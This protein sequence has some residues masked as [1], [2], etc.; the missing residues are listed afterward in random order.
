[1]D[2][3]SP[4]VASRFQP[5]RSTVFNAGLVREPY[6]F[7][8][9]VHNTTATPQ[10]LVM[11]LDHEYTTMD[12]YV[13][14]GGEPA[15]Q[16]ASSD[17]LDLIAAGKSR[18]EVL[19]I[20]FTL[21]AFQEHT[22]YLRLD[23][24]F[25]M[26]VMLALWTPQALQRENLREYHFY[27]WMWGGVLVFAAFFGIIYLALR[28][29]V[30]LYYTLFLGSFL[31]FRILGRLWV[32][33]IFVTGT[34]IYHLAVLLVLSTIVFGLKFSQRL[35]NLSELAPRLNQITN[36]LILGVL[37]GAFLMDDLF[38]RY[39]LIANF[40]I[41]ASPLIWIMGVQSWRKGNEA[42]Q[43]FLAGVGGLLLFTLPMP[44]MALGVL[45]FS[46]YYRPAVELA[47]LLDCIL[48]SVALAIRFRKTYLER[49]QAQQQVI[50][51]LQAN[52]RLRSSFLANVSHELRTPLH[53]MIGLTEMLLKDPHDP[54]SQVKQQQ[55]QV[56]LRNGQRLNGLVDNL[57]EL[58]GG[59]GQPTPLHTEA[60]ALRPLVQ[61][62]LVLLESPPTASP[63]LLNN[64]SPE[65]PAAQAD[66]AKLEQVFI[67][68]L[69]NAR[70]HAPQGAITVE[71]HPQG[72]M[73]RLEVRDQG[74][75]ISP[76]DQERIFEPFEQ[77][78][79]TTASSGK[80][81]G[82]GLS[83]S[84]QIVEAHGGE[85]GVEAPPE[86]GSLFWLTLP[87]APE[88]DEAPTSE[89]LPL[90]S[91]TVPKPLEPEQP[92][93]TV[94]VVDDEVTN[95]YIIQGYL[96]ELNLRVHFCS[97]GAE[98]LDLWQSHAVDLILLDARMP[99]LDGYEV[100]EAIREQASREDLP[101]LFL[102]AYTRSDDIALALQAGAN[103]YLFKPILQ[104]EL[105][106]R[107][108]S[109]LELVQLRRALQQASSPVTS[110]QELLAEAMRLC[111][112]LWEQQTS[113]NLS[114]LAK[115][116]GAWGAHVDQSTGA[117]KS[118]GL[119]RY[120]SASTIPHKPRWRKVLQTLEFLMEQLDPAHP[121]QAAL[122]TLRAQVLQRFS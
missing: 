37:A 113:Q 13:E 122:Q 18:E 9:R 63:P 77:G 55:V 71:A 90:P 60:V 98:A 86:G 56:V 40:V 44:L 51:G 22:Y 59:K 106:A 76:E 33:H 19:G 83:I 118:P 31:Y 45:N 30:Y 23:T 28:E 70:T 49:D 91:W 29:R 109:H 7:R 82:L 54:L 20:P 68:L 78:A 43:Y 36:L 50:E 94:L 53:G 105:Q 87:Q 74:P 41:L 80:G 42:A 58:S 112:R 75:G 69:Q 46:P 73:L 24:Q 95:L 26:K 84:R 17:F 103:D 96:A 121:Q 64:I 104:A 47:A 97:S 66:P 108:L 107:V 5:N 116:S 15:H 12:L 99:N 115:A 88:P 1:M 25:E 114:A 119:R 10:D 101:I 102:S 79:P 81:L 72:A 89:A 8:F 65:L 2:V 48:F 3:R 62:V 120:L 34:L 35:L 38:S 27:G 21:D 14:G 11:F 4:Q 6:W 61:Q 32:D 100:C 92:G 110:D 57:L 93:G 16:V 111:V 39:T 67:N 85:I 117:W 52:D